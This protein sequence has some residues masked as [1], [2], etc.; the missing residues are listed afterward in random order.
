MPTT[1]ISHHLKNT[2]VLCSWIDNRI[3]MRI[4]SPGNI[5][6][7]DTFANP[8]QSLSRIDQGIIVVEYNLFNSELCDFFY[9]T[10]YII[11]FIK[12][13]SPSPNFVGT[14]ATIVGT[15]FRSHYW[16]SRFMF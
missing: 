1:S 5:Q 14:K 6:W 2:Q 16:N 3:Y 10:Y 12:T 13:N 7:F 15:T 8:L 4:T 9:K 11:R